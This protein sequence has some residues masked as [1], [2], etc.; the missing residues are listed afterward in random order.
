MILLFLYFLLLLLS[1][2]LPALSRWLWLCCSI[3]YLCAMFFAELLLL[4]LRL[5]LFLLLLLLVRLWMS[6]YI[7]HIFSILF[8]FTY[9]SITDD[10]HLPILYS[11]GL[12]DW[13]YVVV[14]LQFCTT[15]PACLPAIQS[16]EQL[17]KWNEL[18]KNSSICETLIR[19]ICTF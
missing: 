5:L 19:S 3:C 4:A 10:V 7:I 18:K 9:M 11:W 12:C 14:K 2:I 13:M 17:R 1:F 8:N 15:L 6:V 16:G